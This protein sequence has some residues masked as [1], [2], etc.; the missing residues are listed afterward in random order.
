MHTSNAKYYR[1]I[2]DFTRKTPRYE[3]ENPPRQ[4]RYSKNDTEQDPYSWLDEKDLRRHMTDKEKLECAIDLSVVCIIGK[5]KQT[6]HKIV[7][8]YREAFSFRDEIR[9]CRNMEVKLELNDKITFYIRSLPTKEEEKCRQE[10]RRVMFVW[11]F[12]KRFE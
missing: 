7:L 6:M 11:N 4:S 5:Q 3:T 1:E 9:L 12:K 10:M 8:R 2:Q